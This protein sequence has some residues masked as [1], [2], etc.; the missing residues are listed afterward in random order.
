MAD[1]WI[2]ELTPAPDPVRCCEL[3]EPLPCRI[4]LDSAARTSRLGRYSFLAADPIALV[5]GKGER[6]EQ[7]DL[8]TNGTVALADPIAGVRE[9]LARFRTEPIPDVPPF[10]GGAAGYVA[11]DFGRT[12]ERLPLPRHDDLAVPD[13]A[14]GLYDWALAWDHERSRAWLIST[15]LP[16]RDEERR[17]IRARDRGHGVLRW[18]DGDAPKRA[19]AL[20]AMRISER[21]G[22]APSYGL[23]AEGWE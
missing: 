19:P 11:Y 22:A 20:A 7:L 17:R 6:A 18:L 12:L 5:R 4:F 2:R 16:E 9:L 15:G 13:I 21:N 23:H 8:L 14:L 10:Q 3:L 1:V